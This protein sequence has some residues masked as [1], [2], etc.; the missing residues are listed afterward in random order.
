[1]TQSIKQVKNDAR[2]MP[3]VIAVVGPFRSGTSCVAGMLHTLGVSMGQTFPR[4]APANQKG[5]F[6]C[7]HLRGFLSRVFVWPTL[8]ERKV[9]ADE[10]VKMFCKNIALRSDDSDPIGVKHPALCL[11]VPEMAEAWPELKI[12]SVNRDIE[13]V[14]KSMGSPGLFPRMPEE[15]K[16]E[17]IER[18]I[19]TRDA[20]IERLKIPTLSLDYAD[21]LANPAKAVNDLIAFADI[22]P[23]P[24]RAAAFVDPNLCHN[25]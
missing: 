19:A 6:E 25:N 13:S 20:D 9:Q 18:M 12:V 2:P 11:L 24:D 10:C 5:F 1:M 15:K 23:S 7:Q 17:L 21:V 14:V 8:S 4:S 16:R 3:Q 22:P